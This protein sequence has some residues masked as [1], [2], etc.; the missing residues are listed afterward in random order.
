MNIPEYIKPG[1][2]IGITAPSFGAT[3]EPYISR[4]NEAIRIF[5]QRGYNIKIGATCS[6]SDGLGISTNP[7]AAAKELTGFY[8][9]ST[10]DAII[11]CGGGELMCETMSYV[12]FDAISNANPKWFMGYSDNTN[13]ILPLVTK[14]N[15]AAIYG[16]C[17]TGF[18]KSWE[19]C[20]ID[21]I[22]LLEGK[23]LT[24]SG[25]QKFQSPDKGTE[26]KEENPIS[27]YILDQNKELICNIPDKLTGCQYIQAKGT[28]I[29]G[30]LDV[31]SNLTGT[32]FDN[33]NHFNKHIDGAIWVLEA[34][35]FN[36]M[37]IRRAIWHL[38]E[39][40]WFEKAKA[41]IIGRPLAAW[42]QEFMGVNQ[43]NAVTDIL[44]KYNVPI[45]M[46]AD[47]GHIAPA[48]PLV[49]GSPAQIEVKDGNIEIDFTH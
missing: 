4:F 5:K 37:D 26:A 9:D 44:S 49:M 24:V 16:H 30:C 23:N 18:G 3:T 36:P 25:Y 10:V 39:C 45:I 11:S 41:F 7:K 19:Q 43:Y 40:G 12:D 20:E 28:L 22:N 2:T 46:D 38:D 14:C 35:D 8:L 33:V 31:L 21:T 1:N 15:T 6:M 17:I 32:K 48:M 27:A 34:C 42:K 29:G 47:V 13:F